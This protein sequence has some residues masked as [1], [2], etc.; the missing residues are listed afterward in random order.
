MAKKNYKKFLPKAGTTVA[1]AVA[2][3]MALS[4]QANAAELDDTDILTG[5][6]LPMDETEVK[7]SA[8]NAT[9]EP[10]GINGENAGIK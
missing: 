5:G 6:N 7:D 10:A 8:M 1:V 4:T 3:T 2:M 9:I